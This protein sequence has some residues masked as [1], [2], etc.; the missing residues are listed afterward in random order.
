MTARWFGEVNVPR[1]A[2]VSGAGRLSAPGG[3]GT[4]AVAAVVAE[5]PR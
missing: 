5:G 4:A 1:R 2:E 3:S